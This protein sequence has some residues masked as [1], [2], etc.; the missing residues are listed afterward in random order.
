[1]RRGGHAGAIGEGKDGTARSHGGHRT[2]AKSIAADPP[3]QPSDDRHQSDDDN[4]IY[5]VVASR[6]G[7]RQVGPSHYTVGAPSPE[8]GQD[9]VRPLDS[10]HSVAAQR[11]SQQ[12]SAGQ[13]R[14]L[15]LGWR[16][17][18]FGHHRRYTMPFK[19]LIER[20]H[21]NQRH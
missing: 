3:N 12:E 7:G 14:L 1:M 20:T 4:V 10:R 21:T 6:S 2:L 18:A 16:A 5:A 17:E 8:S 15:D 13:A 9:T 19:D 11:A